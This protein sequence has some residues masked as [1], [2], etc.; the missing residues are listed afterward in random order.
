MAIL[1]QMSIICLLVSFDFS[2]ILVFDNC[3]TTAAV[4]FELAAFLQLRKSQPDLLRSY[5]AGT[6][7]LLLVPISLLAHCT[8]FVCCFKSLRSSVLIALAFATGMVYGLRITRRAQ[9]DRREGTPVALD[10][11]LEE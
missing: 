3:F 2:D 10:V 8:V 6:G 9:S 4:F 11:F 1:L 5:R 7:I